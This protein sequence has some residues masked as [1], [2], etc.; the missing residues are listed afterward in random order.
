MFTGADQHPSYPLPVMTR[1][2]YVP[3][4]LFASAL[5]LVASLLVL[6]A[7]AGAGRLAC[8]QGRW[9]V[10]ALG[11]PSAMVKGG[12]GYYAWYDASGWHLRL[13]GD[14]GATLTGTVSSSAP[15]RILRMSSA[16]RPGLKV[17][18]RNLSF[19]FSATGRAET[20]DF[21][22]TCAGKLDF[23]LGPATVATASPS[24]GGVPAPGPPSVPGAPPVPGKATA[25]PVLPV[26]LGAQGRA[27]ASSF[28]LGRPIATGISGRVVIGPTCPVENPQNPCQPKPANGVV[29]I[30]R[31]AASK[32]GAAGEV[33]GTV[34]SD[35]QGFFTANLAPGRY[36]L[37]VATDKP[38]LPLAKPSIAEVQAGVVTRVTLLLD[39]GIR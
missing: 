17:G 31:A 30:E 5:G 4:S 29:R 2:T 6:T 22:S 23:Q 21:A 3:L 25:T 1:R 35:S 36:L 15:V 39:T 26:F 7:P 33:V 24:G 12:S 8:G 9:P 37:V 16:A 19:T 14:A 38:G 20:I 10:T 32:G 11:T 28:E 18:A 27:P 13:R 34:Q